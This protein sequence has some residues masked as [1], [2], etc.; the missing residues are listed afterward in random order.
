MLV[1]MATEQN[2]YVNFSMFRRSS[3]PIQIAVASS[4][5]MSAAAKK[6]SLAGGPRT[7]YTSQGGGGIAHVH[8]W[9]TCIQTD[10]CKQNV[11]VSRNKTRCLAGGPRTWY[12]AQGG[13]RRLC[14]Q[15][16]H[17]RSALNWTMPAF[18][19]LLMSQIPGGRAPRTSEHPW[20]IGLAAISLPKCSCMGQRKSLRK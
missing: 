5:L 6:S 8:R 10:S 9:T 18:L 11:P 1:D 19:R 13:V 14:P 7:W 3:Q 16:L 12:T 2:V 15:C 4:M 17:L 20:G